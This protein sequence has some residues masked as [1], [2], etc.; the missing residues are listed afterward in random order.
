M[1]SACKST[2]LNSVSISDLIMFV[3][4]IVNALGIRVADCS[5]FSTGSFESM[6]TAIDPPHAAPLSKTIKSPLAP[7]SIP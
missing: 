3:C 6:S 2:R 5:C 4:H 7:E 1:K